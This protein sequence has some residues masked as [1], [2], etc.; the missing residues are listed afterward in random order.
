[1]NFLVGGD[2]IQPITQTTISYHP[3]S[4][5]EGEW[6]PRDLWGSLVNQW[7]PGNGPQVPATLAGTRLHQNPGV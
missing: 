7:G 5:R 4:F 1:M 2:T 6:G 3:P